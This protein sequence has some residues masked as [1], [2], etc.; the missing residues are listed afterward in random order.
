MSVTHSTDAVENNKHL[1][2]AFE[3]KDISM[4]LSWHLQCVCMRERARERERG[5][6][7]E[8]ESKR[9]E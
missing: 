5:Q 7:G 8:R 9:G 6:E 2:S 4:I 3:A 1:S